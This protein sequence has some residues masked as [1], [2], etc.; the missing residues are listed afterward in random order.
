MTTE[1]TAT[2]RRI[3]NAHNACGGN[4]IGGFLAFDE[5]GYGGEWYRDGS[6]VKAAISYPVHWHRVDARHVQDWLNKRSA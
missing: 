6:W 5:D 3:A 2:A 4:L 1:I